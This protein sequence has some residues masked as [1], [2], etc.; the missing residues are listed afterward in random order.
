M[1]IVFIL[2]LDFLGEG[3]E[4]GDRSGGGKGVYECWIDGV[5]G[6]G[7]YVQRTIHA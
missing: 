6:E 1:C 3:G 5:D 4:D 2:I 7:V